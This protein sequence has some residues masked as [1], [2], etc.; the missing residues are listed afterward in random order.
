[1]AA[2]SMIIGRYSRDSSS[3]ACQQLGL[4]C[5]VQRRANPLSTGA[6]PRIARNGTVSVEKDHFFKAPNEPRALI[7]P[8]A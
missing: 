8:A 5:S 6:L 2:Y 4:R 1:M 7:G 3:G